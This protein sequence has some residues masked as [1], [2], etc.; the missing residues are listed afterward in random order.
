M[1]IV[2]GGQ[3][4]EVVQDGKVISKQ[5]VVGCDLHRKPHEMKRGEVID[6]DGTKYY[7]YTC[8]GCWQTVSEREVN[9][10][11]ER[12]KQEKLKQSTLI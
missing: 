5:Y 9:M 6:K 7:Y 3:T 10:A 1:S 12:N 11:V 2:I 8:Q 4:G